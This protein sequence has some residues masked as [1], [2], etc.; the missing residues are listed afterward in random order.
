MLKLP[1]HSGFHDLILK[2]KTLKAEPDLSQNLE[3]TI[4]QDQS[5]QY[6]YMK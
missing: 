2:H 3:N 5:F 1:T 6:L 4:S